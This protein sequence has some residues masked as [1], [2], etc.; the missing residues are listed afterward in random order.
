MALSCARAYAQVY[1][2]TRLTPIVHARCCVFSRTQVSQEGWWSGPLVTQL[3]PLTTFYPAEVRRGRGGGR[4]GGPAAGSFG[5][6]GSWACMAAL[7]EA[8]S[9]GARSLCCESARDN[10]CFP[11]LQAERALTMG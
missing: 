5:M 2:A 7:A 8:A 4:E 3:E 10:N 6:V 9:R 1:K 11:Q